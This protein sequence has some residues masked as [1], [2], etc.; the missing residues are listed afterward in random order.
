MIEIAF[1]VTSLSSPWNV[2]IIQL[3]RGNSGLKLYQLNQFHLLLLLCLKP[4]HTFAVSG[5][6]FW[7]TPIVANAPQCAID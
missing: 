5:G 2:L 1:M 4:L 3:N 7:E 6:V